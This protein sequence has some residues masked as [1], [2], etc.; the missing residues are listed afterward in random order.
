MAAAAG[1]FQAPFQA[2]PQALQIPGAPPRKATL[3]PFDY[4][5]RENFSQ[6][7]NINQVDSFQAMHV[8]RDLWI[9]MPH[10]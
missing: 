3:V 6:I 1:N 9:R 10:A 4:F 8:C 7:M 2:Q 5:V